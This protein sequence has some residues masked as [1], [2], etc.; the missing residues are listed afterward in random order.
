[1]KLNIEG[2]SSILCKA[3]PPKVL[4]CVAPIPVRRIRNHSRSE[5][6]VHIPTLICMD[7][8]K[9]KPLHSH[10]L[11]TSAKLEKLERI[12]TESPIGR[13]GRADTVV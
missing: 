10:D 8:P 4:R 9:L 6:P 11:L 13:F 2:K 5:N 3:C 1:M 12:S 7:S